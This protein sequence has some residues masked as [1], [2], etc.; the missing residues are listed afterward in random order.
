MKA[1]A[2]IATYN[3]RYLLNMHPQWLCSARPPANTEIN[4]IDDGNTD[5]DT[6]YLISI[7][8]ANE[9]L[10]SLQGSK[11]CKLFA[12]CVSHLIDLLPSMTAL[13]M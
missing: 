11:H 13:S 5:Y 7:Y 3:C 12:A 2:G 9:V 8:P 4:V 10:P 6:S 1:A